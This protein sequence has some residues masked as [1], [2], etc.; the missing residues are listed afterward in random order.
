MVS[1]PN[2]ALGL[3]VDTMLADVTPHANQFGP[4]ADGFSV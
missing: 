4:K 1:T 2:M 3:A